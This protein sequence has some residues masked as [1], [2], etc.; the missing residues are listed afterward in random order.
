MIELHFVYQFFPVTEKRKESNIVIEQYVNFSVRHSNIVI[1]VLLDSAL[2]SA[3]KGQDS[4]PPENKS[5]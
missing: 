4:S 3:L 5:A 1:V 2:L